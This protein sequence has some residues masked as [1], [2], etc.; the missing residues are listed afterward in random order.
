MRFTPKTEKEI[1][2]ANLIPVGIYPFE[3]VTAIDTQSN[4]RNDMI[5]LGIKLWDIEGNERHVYD[6][7]LEVME[8]K[9][10]H[11][12][13]ACGLGDKYESG[14]LAAADFEGRTGSL[15][16]GIKKDKTGQYPDQNNVSDY[17]VKDNHE[18]QAP[19]HDSRPVSA[20]LNDEIPF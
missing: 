3:I 15:K 9:L 4:A 7:L 6:Y 18:N 2:E 13:Y 20:I 16:L 17:I 19:K 10:R 11:C 1:Q 5:K 14:V 8:Y 12:A